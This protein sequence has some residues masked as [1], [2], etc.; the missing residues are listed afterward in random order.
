MVIHH[1]VFLLAVTNSAAIILTHAGA[2]TVEVSWI[3]HCITAYFKTSIIQ[4]RL[5][6]KNYH[7]ITSSRIL[8]Q[9]TKAQIPSKSFT[10][11]FT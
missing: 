9:L 6:L 8:G 11:T 1:V 5:G 7:K 4:T 3:S 10:I 2:L